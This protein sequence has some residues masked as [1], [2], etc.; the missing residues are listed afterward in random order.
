MKISFNNFS[1]YQKINLWK[2][3][4]KFLV[5]EIK[6]RIAVFWFVLRDGYY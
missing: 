6:S 4:I 1:S 2:W 3:F 5:D